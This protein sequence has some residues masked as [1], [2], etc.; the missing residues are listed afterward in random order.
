MT[1]S[2]SVAFYAHKGGVGKSTLAFDI[3]YRLQQRG[4]NVVLIDADPQMNTTFKILSRNGE[5]LDMKQTVD[6]FLAQTPT[7]PVQIE[8]WRLVTLF[9][10]LSLGPNV[11]QEQLLRVPNTER[12]FLVP[13]SAL[14]T[15]LEVQLV[16][17][18]KLSSNFPTLAQVPQYFK[19]LLDQL[20]DLFH[21]KNEAVLILIDVSPSTGFFNQNILLSADYISLPVNADFH[22]YTGVRLLFQYLSSWKEDHKGYLNGHNVRI[23]SLIH[24]RY[25]RAPGAHT[26]NVHQHFRNMFREVAEQFANDAT[27]RHNHAINVTAQNSWFYYVQDM[28]RFAAVC[29]DGHFS[30]YELSR[31]ICT[32]HNSSWSSEKVTEIISEIDRIV[33]CFTH[34]LATNE[35]NTSR[36]VIL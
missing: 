9:N 30:V 21:S 12:M 3:A 25:K 18:V 34:L 15:T 24:N 5:S 20:K 31:E 14:L 29:S 17:A 7:A 19:M 16:N 33:S 8:D 1:N 22:S 2:A 28:M 27:Q 6:L 23:F 11:T 35:R 32:K 10:H 36:I 4:T 13:G 26:S